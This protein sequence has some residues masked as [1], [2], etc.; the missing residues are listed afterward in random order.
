MESFDQTFSQLQS[1]GRAIDGEV[2]IAI[3]EGVGSGFMQVTTRGRE[4]FKVYHVFVLR[5]RRESFGL[6]EASPKQRREW[7]Q[8]A[9]A[10]IDHFGSKTPPDIVKCLGDVREVFSVDK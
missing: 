10:F 4:E 9:Q 2:I 1:R 5:I 6:Q 7:C 8:M 3:N